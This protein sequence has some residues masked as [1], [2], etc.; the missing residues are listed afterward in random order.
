MWQDSWEVVAEQDR[1]SQ[2]SRGG[3]GGS[4]IVLWLGTEQH[5]CKFRIGGPT[6]LTYCWA[7][8]GVGIDLPSIHI[9]L[10][11]S[12]FSSLTTYTLTLRGDTKFPE[13]LSRDNFL[14][15]TSLTSGH[16]LPLRSN[17]WDC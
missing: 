17:S 10:S 11:E 1:R 12:P 4:V 14:F 7:E 13:I 9:L 5:A 8:S 2:K 3:S 15:Y 6:E 16:S